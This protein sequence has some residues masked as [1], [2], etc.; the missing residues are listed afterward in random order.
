M[1]APK[2]R[3]NRKA[4]RMAR[5]RNKTRITSAVNPRAI[6]LEHDDGTWTVEESSKYPAR[7]QAKEKPDVT[8][9]QDKLSPAAVAAVGEAAKKALASKQ[10]VDV[11]FDLFRKLEA[12]VDDVT[13][14]NLRH[15]SQ[16]DHI[17]DN[18]V[19]LASKL[20]EARAKLIS[21][22]HALT[23]GSAVAEVDPY[24]EIKIEIINLYKAL[25]LNWAM[26]SGTITTNLSVPTERIPLYRNQIRLLAE[27]GDLITDRE[28]ARGGSHINYK[29]NPEKYVS[30]EK[31][32]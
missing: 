19:L 22:K 15:E 29:L 26:T 17:R 31:E 5:A 2:S 24:E 9:I 8:T 1:G 28:G 12:R 21:L 3:K 11:L 32:E 4:V 16:L 10:D 6:V 13:E 30:T 14:S 23:K 7:R 18:Y 25:P 20:D 27:R